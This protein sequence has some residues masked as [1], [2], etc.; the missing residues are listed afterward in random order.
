[1]PELSKH[2]VIRKFV[3]I[4]ILIFTSFILYP[5][6]IYSKSSQ[7][8]ID[9]ILTN[10]E[11]IAYKKPDSLLSLTDQIIASKNYNDYFKTKARLAKGFAYLNKG[12]AS[13][14]L[15]EFINVQ[16][17]YQK[18]GDIHNLAET[19]NFIGR[20]YYS[21]KN[22]TIAI[23][24][25]QRAYSIFKTLNDSK[26]QA[27][28][29]GNLGIAYLKQD[30]L[31]YAE[32]YIHEAIKIK[33]EYKDSLNIAI[34]KIYEARIYSQNKKL[35]KAIEISREAYQTLK[36]GENYKYASIVSKDISNY[37][38]SKNDIKNA[39]F[40]AN[41][42]LNFAQIGSFKNDIKEAYKLLSNIAKTNNN[43]KD[44]LEYYVQ[45]DKI[46][47]SLFLSE[48]ENRIQAVRNKVI[49]ENQNEK[50]AL[51]E[52]SKNSSEMIRNML[53]ISILFFIII[54]FLLTKRYRNQKRSKELLDK[55]NEEIEINSI[56]LSKQSKKLELALEELHEKNKQLNDLI[57]EKS[58]IL[59]IAA[60]DLKNPISMIMFNS[61]IMLSDNQKLNEEEIENRLQNIKQLS[62][63]MNTIINNLIET[64]KLESSLIKVEHRT[65]D[66]AEILQNLCY[67]YQ[68]SAN[69]K[70]ILIE[71]SYSDHELLLRSDINLLSSVLDNLISNAIKYTFPNT[72]VKITASIKDRN[73]EIRIKDKGQGI[74]PDEVHLLFKKFSRLS[75]TPTGGEVSTGL[76]LAIVKQSC[77]LL[78]ASVECFSNYG[79]G[80]EFVVTH[81]IEYHPY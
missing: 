14:A 11:E 68:I 2:I 33:R 23:G 67:H 18:N 1:M 38:M 44:A 54:I 81:P 34:L 13:K 37:F 41:Q 69:Q 24:Y 45:Y 56:Q 15:E 3:K 77:N 71:S 27:I 35:D 80:A 19:Y 64:D 50:I 28:S 29:L 63:K 17:K 16:Q 49:I 30:S 6:I 31:Q 26:N 73:I 65:V 36:I 62:I 61:D 8:D 22:Y 72:K 10:I 39:S 12:D 9:S 58:E 78:G 4:F 32:Q 55:K 52:A 21:Q 74:H 79:D 76:G 7:I 46:K 47:D 53:I 60:H 66:L 51:L 59:S 20:L 42:A 75:S 48:T 57:V 43:L 70:N 25:Y 5:N 40:Y